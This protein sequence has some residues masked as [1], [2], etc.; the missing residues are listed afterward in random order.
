MEA[1]VT[2]TSSTPISKVVMSSMVKANHTNK[3]EINQL[4]QAIEEMQVQFLLQPCLINSN[5]TGLDN[6]RCN[7]ANL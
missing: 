2:Q 6:Q 1:N 4:E 7:K 5:K 3:I